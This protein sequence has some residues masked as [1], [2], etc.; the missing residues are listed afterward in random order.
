MNIV[1]FIVVVPPSEHIAA[2]MKSP[3]LPFLGTRFLMLFVILEFVTVIV[4]LSLNIAAPPLSMFLD[5]AD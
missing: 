4:P 5:L 1:L 2:S 3:L